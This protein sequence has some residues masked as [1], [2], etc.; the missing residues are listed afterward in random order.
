MSDGNPRNGRIVL[1]PFCSFRKLPL[2]THTCTHTHRG[3]VVI[4]STQQPRAH[5]NRLW[6]TSGRWFG[7]KTLRQQSWSPILWNLAR[8]VWSYTSY[9]T[10]LLTLH[11]CSY[12][13]LCILS[14]LMQMKCTQY[15]PSNGSVIY[16]R[17]KVT[18]DKV[19]ELPDY[20]I[21]SFLVSPVSV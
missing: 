20:V 5:W 2:T 12:Y 6:W 15:W 16:G 9:I 19:V 4:L 1:H 8:W 21:R 3:T 17:V 18:P 13:D 14:H 10:T 7:S 11:V